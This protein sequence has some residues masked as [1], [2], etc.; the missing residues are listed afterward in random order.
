MKFWTGSNRKTIIGKNS[1][2]SWHMEWWGLSLLWSKSGVFVSGSILGVMH[3]EATPQHGGNIMELAMGHG[4]HKKLLEG[5]SV[6]PIKF[7]VTSIIKTHHI[8]CFPHKASDFVLQTVWTSY[9]YIYIHTLKLV[10]LTRGYPH[11]FLGKA[12]EPSASKVN[13]PLWGWSL[14][15]VV[16]LKQRNSLHSYLKNTYAYIN[17]VYVYMYCIILYYITLYYITLYHI[18]SYHIIYIILDILY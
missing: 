16:F 8:T 6:N 17:I 9:I 15:S 10:P 12:S 13:E 11:D 3:S 14:K 1:H 7:R 2:H 4:F 5:K 18:I